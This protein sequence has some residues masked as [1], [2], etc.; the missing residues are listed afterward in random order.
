MLTFDEPSHTYYWNGKI[1]PNVT[2]VLGP[3]TDYS[4]VKPDVL[5]VARQK[6][7]AVHRMVELWA[8]DDLNA[9]TL[10]EWMRPVLVQ[11]LK[12]VDDTSLKVIASEKK[13]WHP[14]FKYAGTFD[15]RVTRRGAPGHGLIDI[16]RSFLAGASIGLQTAAY[17]EAENAAGYTRETRIQWRGALKLRED[18]AYRYQPFGATD[19]FSMFTVALKHYTTGQILNEWKE[20]NK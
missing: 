6:G 10:P 11:W 17:A 4:M 15:L 20:K 2:R 18:G 13:V 19:D 1:V 16:K 8:K 5:E 12:F 14:I 9:D 7:V 3:L